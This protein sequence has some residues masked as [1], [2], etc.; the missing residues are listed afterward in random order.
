MFVSGDR[1]IKNLATWEPNAFD[2]WGRGI[3]IGTFAAP[4]FPVRDLQMVDVHWPA[5]RCFEPISGLLPAPA[6]SQ[7]PSERA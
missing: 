2:A 3:G 5:G 7:Q 4:P 6:D 1:V